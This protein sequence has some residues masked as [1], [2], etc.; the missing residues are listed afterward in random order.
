MLSL[1]GIFSL[2][3]LGLFLILPVFAVFARDLPE[4]TPFLVGLAIGIY[5]LTQAILQIPFGMMSDRYGRKPVISAGLLIF[6]IGSV[7]AASSDSIYGI[8]IGRALQGAGAIA[9]AILALAA[10]LTREQQ[11]TKAMAVIGMSIGASF[12]L[13]LVL[14]PLLENWVGVSGIFWLTAILSVVAIPVLWW[15]TPTPLVASR[16]A[17]VNLDSTKWGQMLAHPQ[18]I[19]MDFGIFALHLALTAFFVV[20]PLILLDQLEI[21]GTSHWK[22]Y[23]PVLALSILG[24]LPIVV[25]AHKFGRYRTAMVLA[26]T[27]LIIAQ[28]LFAFSSLDFAWFMVALWLFFS[29]FNA[30]EAMLPS[31][32]SRLAPAGGKGTV[33]GIYNS[34]EFVGIFVG[35]AVGGWLYGLY[36]AGGVFVFGAGSLLLWVLLVISAPTLKLLDSLTLTIVPNYGGDVH[37]MLVKLKTI[38]GVEDTTIITDQ[39]LVY[40]KID[41]DRFDPGALA[42]LPELQ[43]V[44][45]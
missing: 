2:R 35:G 17:D 3:M 18:L 16:H 38:S 37:E 30:L 31:L 8:I 41:R 32:V 23:L 33:M 22:V 15:Y 26:I 6:A 29:G 45:H 9:A 11:R 19:R 43:Q 14:G 5:G 12:M 13:A 24:M 1:A 4:T 40:I 44:D 34:F 27:L 39:S 36:G 20:V 42:V 10:D 28:G 25:F 21:P 7:V